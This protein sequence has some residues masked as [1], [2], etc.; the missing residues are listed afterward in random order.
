[1]IIIMAVFSTLINTHHMLLSASGIHHVFVSSSHQRILDTHTVLK[2]HKTKT[3]T[4]VR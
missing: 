2:S 3:C 1:M 4:Q